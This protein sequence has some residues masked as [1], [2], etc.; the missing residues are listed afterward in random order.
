MAGHRFLPPREFSET[1]PRGRVPEDLRALLLKAL[2]KR[3]EKRIAS[4]Q[5]FLLGLTAI[6]E[7]FPLTPGTAEEFWRVLQP[8]VPEAGRQV[9]SAEKPEEK[10]RQD[11]SPETLRA[12]SGDQ[13]PAGEPAPPQPRRLPSLRPPP[14]PLPPPG[15]GGDFDTW[16]FRLLRFPAAGPETPPA[17]CAVLRSTQEPH[18]GQRILLTG[19]S[20]VLGLLLL[21]LWLPRIAEFPATSSLEALAR[22]VLPASRSMQRGDLI[23]LGGPGIDAPEVKYFPAYAYPVAARGSGRTCSIRV[24]VLVDEKGRPSEIHIDSRD[25]SVLGFDATALDAARQVK[26]FPPLRD[27]IPG[28]MW[29]QLL[30]FFSEQAP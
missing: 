8:V 25:G 26:F 15:A 19:S 24:R 3:P 10:T 12:W 17:A 28:K 18:P 29:T 16:A 11:I 27:G 1:D 7:R 6:Q 30:F 9:S 23:V 4:S 20:A 21:G 2:A 14:A 13:P 22:P 5:D